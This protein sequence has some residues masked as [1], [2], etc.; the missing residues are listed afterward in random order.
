[1]VKT[2]LNR[3][4]P[5]TI[6]GPADMSDRNEMIAAT[7]RHY[8]SV[9]E[10]FWEGTRDHDVSQNYDALLRAINPEKTRKGLKIL[11]LGCGPGRD[12]MWFRDAGHEPTGLD[13]A[14]SFVAQARARSGCPVWQQDFLNLALPPSTF[15]G[16]FANATLFHVPKSDILRVLGQ[17]RDSLVPDGVLFASNP[18]GNDEE[19]F[20]GGRF[21]TFYRDESWLAL[22]ESAGFDPIEHYWRPDGLPREQQPWLASVWRRSR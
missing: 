11:D 13:G 5:S 17:L 1:M 15:D 4:I 10:T 22:V 12:L 3:T 21:C 2:P 20:T 6:D 18:R 16:V 7:L 9:S 19:S 14:G 8:D